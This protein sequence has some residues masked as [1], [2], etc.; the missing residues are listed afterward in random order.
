MDWTR[1]NR[2]PV[3]SQTG[4]EQFHGQVAHVECARTRIN[5]GRGH[6]LDA[7]TDWTR[8]DQGLGLCAVMDWTWS[9]TSCGHDQF[10]DWTRTLTGRVCGHCVDACGLKRGCCVDIPGQCADMPRLLLGYCVEIARTL[11]GCGVAIARKL[12]RTLR[13]RCA[14]TV[15]KSCGYSPDIRR[16]RMP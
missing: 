13:V 10:T 7:A 3:N 14:E 12:R 16:T 4:Q 6:G 5:C 9:R 1:T 8:A 2:G 15:W 11:Y